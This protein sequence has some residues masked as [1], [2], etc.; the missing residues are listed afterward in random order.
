[1]IKLI[2]QIILC[3]FVTLTPMDPKE[4]GYQDHSYFIWCRCGLSHDVRVMVP[5]GG[6]VPSLKK[7]I[8]M[9][10]F[11]GE[12]GGRT[13]LVW[14][15]KDVPSWFL[16]TISNSHLCLHAFILFIFSMFCC[17]MISMLNV[18]IIRLVI[19]LISIWDTHVY[20]DLYLV[21]SL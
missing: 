19:C 9:H 16:V 12:F 3:G 15:H 1:M 21:F 2:K 10:H 5:W 20:M 13:T 11:Q 18:M 8:W 14:R 6:C 7:T 4:Y 17:F